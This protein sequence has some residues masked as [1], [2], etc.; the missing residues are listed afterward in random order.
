MSAENVRIGNSAATVQSNG[1]YA[2]NEQLNSVGETATYF[3]HSFLV[4]IV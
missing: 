3:I 2:R 4:S 1:K